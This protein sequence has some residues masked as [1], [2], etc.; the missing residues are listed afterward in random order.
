MYRGIEAT[1]DQ[2]IP[3]LDSEMGGKVKNLFAWH[4]H[5]MK[6]PFKDVRAR[7]A[8]AAPAAAAAG[9]QAAPAETQAEAP[10]DA[11]A[12]GRHTASA[13][14]SKKRAASSS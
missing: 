10:A 1:A 13:A 14:G 12:T 4:K 5:N 3:E 7:L 8:P 9:T 2:A 6:Y 11:K